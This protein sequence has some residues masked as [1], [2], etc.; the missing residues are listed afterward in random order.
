M[1]RDEA[2]LDQALARVEV[3]LS[4]AHQHRRNDLAARQIVQLKVPLMEVL[5]Q[6]QDA[7]RLAEARETASSA[8]KRDMFRH[9]ARVQMVLLRG[10]PEELV[11]AETERIFPADAQI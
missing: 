11:E 9:K 4:A 5:S 8:I 6:R 2:A 1:I 3:S 7:Q 10:L